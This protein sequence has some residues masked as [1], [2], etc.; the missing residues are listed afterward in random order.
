MTRLR[1]A[2]YGTGHGHA[3]GKL[4]ALRANPDVEVAGV[5]EPDASRRSVLDKP[6]QRLHGVRWY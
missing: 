2:Q 4:V 5:F 6:G 1:I 3:A